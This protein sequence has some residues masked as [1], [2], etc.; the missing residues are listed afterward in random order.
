MIIYASYDPGGLRQ[1]RN[2][3]ESAFG[4]TA[5]NWKNPNVYPTVA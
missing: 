5:P 2:T 1:G 4:V 3:H